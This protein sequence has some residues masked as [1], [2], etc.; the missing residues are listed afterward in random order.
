MSAISEVA[1]LT[2]QP[3]RTEILEIVQQPQLAAGVPAGSD[4]EGQLDED[5]E[6]LTNEED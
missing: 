4:D 6:A 3:R 2:M 5:L 1:A